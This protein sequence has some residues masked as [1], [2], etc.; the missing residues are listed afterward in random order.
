MQ[1]QFSSQQTG[2]VLIPNHIKNA[3]GEWW[4]GKRPGKHLLLKVTEV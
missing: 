4:G 3:L 2:T 1:V